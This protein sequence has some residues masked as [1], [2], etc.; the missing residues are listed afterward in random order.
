MVSSSQQMIIQKH[1]GVKLKRNPIVTILCLEVDRKCNVL[2]I[3][4]TIFSSVYL[5]YQNRATIVL[6]IRIPKRSKLSSL[7]GNNIKHHII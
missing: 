5:V 3:R 4:A 7:L 1:M 2:D 6:K